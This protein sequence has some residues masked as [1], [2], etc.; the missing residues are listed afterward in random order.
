MNRDIPKINSG[1]TNIKGEHFNKVREIAYK[2][3]E[4]MGNVGIFKAETKHSNDFFCGDDL[5]EGVYVYQTFN[6]PKIAYRI[7]KSFADYNFNGFMDDKL[8]QN[9]L[10]RK[11]GIVL[12]EFPTGVVTL[13]GRIIGQEIPYYE[14]GITLNKYFKENKV[15]N[16]F[17]IYLQV[18]NI[19]KEMFDHG[20]I[21][22]DNHSGNYLIDLNDES[23]HAIDF[24]SAFIRF[25]DALTYRKQLFEN[26]KSMINKLNILNETYEKV[27]RFEEVDNFSDAY[28]QIYTLRK[29]LK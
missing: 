5:E 15:S 6:N 14:K 8:I 9:L 26:Y 23:V 2:K 1:F 13:E 27:G 21:Y 7:Y 24:D 16:S 18:L 22:L 25:E 28:N 19:I 12:T 4:L 29:K 20:I 17:D 11:D 3:G 10:E